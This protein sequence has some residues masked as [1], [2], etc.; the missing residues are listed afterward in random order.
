M[1]IISILTII[2]LTL[3]NWDI[4]YALNKLLN[5]CGVGLLSGWLFDHFMPSELINV[6]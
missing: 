2:I 1:E 6:R 4:L 5:T 3:A